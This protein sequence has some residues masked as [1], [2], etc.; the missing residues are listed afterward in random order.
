[1]R[2]YSVLFISG[3]Q[4]R[5]HYFPAVPFSWLIMTIRVESG[6]QSKFKEFLVA[7]QEYRFEDTMIVLLLTQ[8]AMF[9][10]ITPDEEAAIKGLDIP[11]KKLHVRFF[12]NMYKLPRLGPTRLNFRSCLLPSCQQ[13]RRSYIGKYTPYSGTCS[14]P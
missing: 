6:V 2:S 13:N 9:G 4:R 11:V 14:G 10:I 7:L 1:M 12:I 3:I 5:N 8:L